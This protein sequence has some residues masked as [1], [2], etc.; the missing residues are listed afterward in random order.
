M[1]TWLNASWGVMD[2]DMDSCT[3]ATWAR[4]RRHDRRRGHGHMDMDMDMD[5]VMGM[6]AWG[7]T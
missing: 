5:M 4:Y 1:G 7:R 6:G 2:V 3:H